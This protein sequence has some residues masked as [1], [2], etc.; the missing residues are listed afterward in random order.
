[1]R[2]AT[3]GEPW[4]LTE[5]AS[6][7]PSP[8]AVAGSIV[9]GLAAILGGLLSP[10]VWYLIPAGAVILAA[11][12]L[13][14][15]SLAKTPPVLVLRVDAD[16]LTVGPAHHFVPWDR[17]S[18]VRQVEHRDRPYLR[19]EVTAPYKVIP[20]RSKRVRQ[21]GPHIQS[22]NGQPINIAENGLGV[23]LAELEDEIRSRAP[24]PL[25]ET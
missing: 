1:M 12:A 19:V 24:R 8:R 16:G 14:A 5:R 6:Y 25:A 23:S 22:F 2:G 11:A 4:E 18:S 21:I 7:L 20:M 15:R 3:S 17:V 9:F 10:A 13:G